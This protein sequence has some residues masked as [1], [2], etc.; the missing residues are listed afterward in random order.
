MY[1]G[2]PWWLSGLRSRHCHCNSSCDCCD[3]GLIPGPG[4]CTCHRNGQKMIYIHKDIYIMQH[5]HTHTHTHTQL[6]LGKRDHTTHLGLLLAFMGWIWGYRIRRILETRDSSSTPHFHMH[7]YFALPFK[8]QI[9][10]PPATIPQEYKAFSS[11]IWAEEEANC[12]WCQVQISVT[13]GC[14]L[15]GFVVP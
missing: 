8:S 5:T 13:T 10:S 4:T 14:I 11:E 9:P 12:Q 15:Q 2:I 6:H 7:G 3:M 1:L